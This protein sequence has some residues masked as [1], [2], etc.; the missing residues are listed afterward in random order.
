MT[1]PAGAGF[2][3]QG[4]KSFGSE[5]QGFDRILPVNLLVG[6]NNAGK[7]ALLDAIDVALSPEKYESRLHHRAENPTTPSFDVAI[8][9]AEE[10]LR[11][12]LPETTSGG[13]V[14]GRNHWETGRRF[15]GKRLWWRYLLGDDRKPSFVRIET[16]S[17]FP[18]HATPELLGRVESPFRGKRF[19]RVGADRDIGPEP[20][21]AAELV[22]ES[23]G[24]GFTAALQAL[25]THDQYN[26]EE[27][28]D[29]IVSGV[30]AVLEPD[31]RVTRLTP[32]KR[33]RDGLWELFLHEE[34]K[35]AVA[36]SASGSGLKTVLLV[37]G[38]LE[39]ERYL[40]GDLGQL[41]F[42][43]EEPENN[44]HP[45]VLRRLLAY[46]RAVAVNDGVTTF[47]T[48][49]SNVGIDYFTGDQQAQLLSVRH[50]GRGSCVDVVR[51]SVDARNV[52]D[53]LGIR[54][55]DLLQANGLVWVEGP[56]DRLHVTRWVEL[57]SNGTLREGAHYQVVFYGGA[58]L[59]HLSA[60]SPV[61]D[62]A[63]DLLRINRNVALVMDS[64]R[65]SPTEELGAAKE[66]LIREVAAIR[67]W[68]WVT[69]GRTIE[70]YVPL[71]VLQ[72][73]FGKVMLDAPGLY[74]TFDE[75][76]GE[77]HQTRNA[78]ERYKTEFAAAVRGL[79]TRDDLESTLDLKDRLTELVTCIRGWNGLPS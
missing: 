13:P 40:R 5:P 25:L 62:D 7:S 65:S 27:F 63:I 78:F 37:V 18:R 9:L 58:L 29:R 41:L 59:K 8:E 64:D 2:V 26:N 79:T 72:A 70:H 23:S 60:A 43:V 11:R 22:V 20:E 21:A 52:L 57:W 42:A 31:L 6:R 74:D 3:V 45:A 75:Y 17:E 1:V 56:S 44:L 36:L 10:P 15:V 55:S 4:F 67:G 76:Y 48:T 38:L 35:G 53:E 24:R 66:R 49:H 30:N 73:H 39:I 77:H 54:A 69:E 33:R 61:T 71:R 50:D 46:I 14:P 19:V 68:H 12:V 51:T 16:D 34:H 28:H 32:K 47:V